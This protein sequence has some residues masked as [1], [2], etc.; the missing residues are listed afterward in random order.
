MRGNRSRD[1]KPERRL[2]S[3]LHA[4][5][6]R[7]RVNYKVLPK[8]RRTADVAFVKARVAVFVDGCFWHGCPEH[9]R[10]ATKNQDFWVAKVV[11]NRR[12]DSETD[13]LLALAGWQ[14]VR[15][16]EHEDASQ[17]AERVAALLRQA[18]PQ[19]PAG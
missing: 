10:P 16:W 2:R 5:G 15:V 13:S 17:A 1:T 19:A 4:M 6:L 18:T 11:S 7:Y 8:L 14:V 3:Q 9:Y 12:R